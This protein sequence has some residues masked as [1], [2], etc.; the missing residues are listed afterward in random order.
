[1]RLCLAAIHALELALGATPKI[2]TTNRFSSTEELTGGEK[3]EDAPDAPETINK[4]KAQLVAKTKL[5]VMEDVRR[6]Q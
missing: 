5:W 2:C 3:E 1:M 6:I 4:V